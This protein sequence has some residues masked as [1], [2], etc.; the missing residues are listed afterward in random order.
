MNLKNQ[1]FV[2]RCITVENFLQC[3]QE[4]IEL[5]NP[6]WL[7]LEHHLTVSLKLTLGEKDFEMLN[8][9]YDSVTQF[10]SMQAKK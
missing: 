10:S 5:G 1:I 4:Y 2:A 6:Y 7:P 9:L 3:V 8:L